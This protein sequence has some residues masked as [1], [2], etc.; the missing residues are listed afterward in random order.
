MVLALAGRSPSVGDPARFND[1]DASATATAVASA[2]EGPAALGTAG[3]GIA[4]LRAFLPFPLAFDEPA[5]AGAAAS[6]MSTSSALSDVACA[7]L[8]WRVN[9]L[10]FEH[11]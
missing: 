8:S 2:G 9:A 4:P 1:P 11:K 10:A 5:A 6:P 7:A 3:G